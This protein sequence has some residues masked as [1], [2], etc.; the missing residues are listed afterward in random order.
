M[1]FV[2]EVAQTLTR[3]LGCRVFGLVLCDALANRA[4]PSDGLLY[5]NVFNGPNLCGGFAVS[6]DGDSLAGYHAFDDLRK[7]RLG[8]CET[9]GLSHMT[10]LTYLTRY[11]EEYCN[12]DGGVSV[13][14]KR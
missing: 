4:D 3:R 12:R 9:H 13:I 14:M 2:C 10:S 7:V 1:S 11:A 8:L 5:V 6:Q